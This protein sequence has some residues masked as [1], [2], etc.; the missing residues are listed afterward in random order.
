[1]ELIGIFVTSFIVGL[2]GAMSP[3]PLSAI[4]FT[5]GPRSG[6]WTGTMLAV[7]H[8]LVEGPL[9]IAIAFGFGEWLRKPSVGSIIGIAGGLVLAWM[10][11]GLI[12]GAWQKSISL[13]ELSAKEPPAALRVGLVPAGILLSVSNPY[14]S[15]WWASIG[16]GFILASWKY[17][18]VGLAVFYLAHWL[19]DFSWLTALSFLTASG[20]KAISDKVYRAILF[21]CGLFLLAFSLYFLYSGIRFARQ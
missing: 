18:V 19:T 6:K 9:V 12:K 16:A 21:G 3:G 7:G 17:G 20:R 10:G 14:W 8:G 15:L 13:K 5:E 4:A 2:S 1:M 11:W